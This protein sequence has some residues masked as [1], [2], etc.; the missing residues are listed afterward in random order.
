[1]PGGFKVW[2]ICKQRYARGAYSG[3]GAR[4]FS[5]R[6]N[7]AGVA[8]VY[9]AVSLSLAALEVFVH[10]EPVAEPGDLVS[11]A[12]ELPVDGARVAEEKL[13][14][15]SRLPSDWRR[16]DHP[17]LQRMGEEWIQSMRSLTMLVPSVVVD[18]E[19]NLL[20]NP[21][22]PDAVKIEIEEPK[23]FRFDPRMFRRTS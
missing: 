1:M 19:W 3:E 18:G 9:T 4:I 12:A 11:I 23:P 20:V 15:L 6:W 16:L 21:A 22:H 17:G 10:L 13:D 14:I 2:R 7:P 5:A 8:M